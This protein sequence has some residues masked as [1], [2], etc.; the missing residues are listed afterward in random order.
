MDLEEKAMDILPEVILKGCIRPILEIRDYH[1]EAD[2][3]CLKRLIGVLS[4]LF[5]NHLWENFKNN[6]KQLQNILEK[7][8]HSSQ[9][10]NGTN[11]TGNVQQPT[12]SRDKASEIKVGACIICSFKMLP[13]TEGIE[14]QTL[15]ILVEK[16]LDLERF[17]P[18]ATFL[19]NPLRKALAPFLNRFPVQSIIWFM[20]THPELKHLALFLHIFELEESTNLREAMGEKTELI[21]DLLKKFSGGLGYGEPTAGE[22]E[23]EIRGILLQI[24]H[25]LADKCLGWIERQK[26]IIQL[27]E[28]IWVTNIALESIKSE[29]QEKLSN[30]YI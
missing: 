18:P 15:P 29:P 14:T 6:L 16:V 22:E 19:C 23:R 25:I 5:N 4:P 17:L 21:I 9:N 26:N 28:K 8:Y 27:F 3:K 11:P 24:V 7:P 10:T 30:R 2:Y 20:K 1:S 13:S 12:S